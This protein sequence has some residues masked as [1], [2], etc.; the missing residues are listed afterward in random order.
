MRDRR[1]KRGEAGKTWHGAARPQWAGNRLLQYLVNK[2]NDFQE[3]DAKEQ[4]GIGGSEKRQ[5]IEARTAAAMLANA[6]LSLEARLGPSL[7]VWDQQYFSTIIGVFSGLARLLGDGEASTEVPKI[8]EVSKNLQHDQ[9]EA[10]KTADSL[11]PSS[12]SRKQT[13]AKWSAVFWEKSRRAST[14]RNERLVTRE[15]QRRISTWKLSRDK[16]LKRGRAQHE[17]Q[18]QAKESQ[19]LLYARDVARLYRAQRDLHDQLTG[20]ERNLEITE[21]AAAA[22][23]LSSGVLHDVN[24]Y[25]AV[26]RSAAELL[27]SELPELS[28]ASREDLEAIAM[29][30]SRAGSL[31][32]KFQFM[33]R[34]GAE[35]GVEVDLIEVIMGARAL[36]KRQLDKKEIN[37]IA[38]VN[39]DLPHLEGDPAGLEEVFI[40][41]VGNSVEILDPG[42]SVRVVAD[43]RKTDTGEEILLLVEDTGPG[44]PGELRDTLFD[45][46]VTGREGGTGLGLFLVKRIVERHGGSI[47]LVSTPGRGARFLIRLPSSG[48]LIEGERSSEARSIGRVASESEGATSMKRQDPGSEE[49]S[50][51]YPIT[52]IVG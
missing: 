47:E 33:A 49:S 45:P 28:S 37:F 41:L 11:A 24:H 17:E 12:K 15:R 34:P 4:E 3:E 44:V 52:S 10:R 38:E 18:A 25:L 43:S 36:M 42:E 29:S 51:L 1:S 19:L 21:K 48:A 13:S 6:A 14:A 8:R 46:F 9:L 50:S 40:N 7:G 32:H 27:Q 30:A 22:G 20:M 5:R 35:Q 31:I 23:L 39:P 26:I 2:E 16:A